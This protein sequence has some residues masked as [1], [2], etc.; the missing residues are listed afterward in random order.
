[1]TATFHEILESL[2][3]LYA[4]LRK[5]KLQTEFAPWM[6]PSIK[7]LMHKRDLTKDWR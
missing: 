1:M 4:P 2:L 5:R 7:E 6:N 3:N